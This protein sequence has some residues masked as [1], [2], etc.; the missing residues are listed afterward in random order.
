MKT[1]TDVQ[2][3]SILAIVAGGGWASRNNSG[4]AHEENADGSIRHVRYGFANTSK[5][6]NAVFKTGDLL[7]TSPA[8]L[9]CM[10][11]CKHPLWHYTGDETELAQWNA[12]KF[13]R[14]RGGRAGFVTHPDQAVAI[15]LGING[16]A[17]DGP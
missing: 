3:A 17:Y 1:E 9:F 6:F 12:I 4:V 5:K 10:W 8:G 7:G 11:E 15:M 13:I 14:S 2:N 16:G